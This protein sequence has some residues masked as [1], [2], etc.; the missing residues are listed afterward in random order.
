VTVAA[1]DDR[2]ASPPPGAR[3]GAGRPL[4]YWGS[5]VMIAT[6]AMLFL[7]LLFAY[8]Q[9]RVRA[10]RWP[11][12]DIAE[13]ELVK[14]GFRSVVLLASSIP[15]HLA[16]R[17]AEEGNQAKLRWSLAVG[18]LMG[19]VFLVG[20]FEEWAGLLHEFTPQTNAY[21][22]LFYTI[23]G[24][25]A[26]HLMIGLLIAGYLFIGAVAGRYENASTNGVKNGI[27]YWHFVD[28]VWVAVYSTLYLSVS[29]L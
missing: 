16:D 26:L 29:L 9:L 22:S 23:T 15:M 10:D 28:V 7:L 18:W 17:A 8:N 13:P 19:A 1:A 27:L 2:T 3:G 14:S 25:H 6:E 4:G 12:G 5:M 11:L 20:H 21:G 24:L